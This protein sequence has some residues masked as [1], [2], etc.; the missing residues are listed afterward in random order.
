MRANQGVVL[1]VAVVWAGQACGGKSEHASSGTGGSSN[2][3][4]SAGTGPDSGGAGGEPESAGAAGLGETGHAGKSGGGRSS[5]GRN[6]GG[7]GGGVA[8]GGH[9]GL[10]CD[11]GE[12]GATSVVGAVCSAGDSPNSCGEP[13][14]V[15][16]CTSQQRVRGKADGCDVR[17]PPEAPIP[18]RDCVDVCS[19]NAPGPV[20]CGPGFYCTTANFTFT[21]YAGACADGDPWS[22]GCASVPESCP[23]TGPTDWVC[24]RDGQAYRSLCEAHRART[25]LP[26]Y[27]WE[28]VCTPPSDDLYQCGG[29]FCLKDLEVCKIVDGIDDHSW[30]TYSCDPAGGAGG[31]SGAGGATQ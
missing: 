18:A 31:E 3:S 11:A 6:Q 21:S 30:A 4:G 25:D 19:S 1:W 23:P 26:V 20:A 28:V 2:V 12:S 22:C 17:C 7:T 13:Y 16:D 10:N 27:S 14:C 15:V 9:G 29:V 24:A 5:G 8:G